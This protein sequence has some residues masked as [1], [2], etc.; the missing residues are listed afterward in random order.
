MNIHKYEEGWWVHDTAQDYSSGELC[1]SEEDALE[2]A[3]DYALQEA[4][5]YEITH[6]LTRTVK[7]VRVVVEVDDL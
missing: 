7:R 3:R 6:V 1:M 4:A 5:D 2:T